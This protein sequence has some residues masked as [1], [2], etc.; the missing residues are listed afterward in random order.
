MRRIIYTIITVILW[1]WAFAYDFKCENEF[2]DTLC[3]TV[4]SGNSV[5][6]APYIETSRWDWTTQNYPP[7]KNKTLHIP[8]KVT[9]AGQTYTVTSIGGHA[10]SCIQVDTVYFPRTITSISPGITLNYYNS[11]SCFIMDENNPVY[12]SQDGVLYTKDM[13]NLL[14]YP[15]AK[16]DSIFQ[17]PEG[18]Q[19]IGDVSI[20]NEGVHILEMPLSLIEVGVGAFLSETLEEIIFQD[21]ITTIK[22]YAFIGSSNLKRLVLG[23]KLQDINLTCIAR[24]SPTIVECRS[25]TP[26]IC[27][28]VD[29]ENQFITS[30]TLLVPR[31][32]VTAYQMAEGWNQFGTIHTIEPPIVSGLD[33]ATISWVQNFSA[34]GYV[35]HLY[36]DAEH[37][38]L[39]MTLTFDARGYLIGITLGDSTPLQAAADNPVYVP[40]RTADDPD[41]GG[42]SEPTR[43][44]VEYYSFTI[45]SLSP[46]RQY[47]YVRQSLAGDRVIDEE[48]GSFETLPDGAP[49]GV[50]PLLF[51]PQPQKTFENGMLRIRKNGN[52]YNVN[53]TKVD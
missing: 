44:Y 19:K 22:E 12:A 9:Y 43:R 4:L 10:L 24:F 42:D 5:E 2:G 31:K 27:N 8:E 48:T 14:A 21:N 41:E 3:Y 7:F 32:S 17:V 50:N 51:E 23:N 18:V 29:V 45:H 52:T 30:S 25:I 40:Q 33:N 47:Y 35:W 26:P 49:T 20:H 11:I 34:T 1:S 37:T 38:Q 16:K 6:L 13:K 39:V 28:I 46:G 15:F 36:S 53:G